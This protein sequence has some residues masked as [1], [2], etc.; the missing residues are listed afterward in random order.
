MATRPSNLPRRLNVAVES[1]PHTCPIWQVS[2]HCDSVTCLARDETYAASGSREGSVHVAL[3]PS[4]EPHLEISGCGQ[5]NCLALHRGKL[6]I[7]ADDGHHASLC[8]WDVARS[9][10]VQELGGVR[11][12]SSPTSFAYFGYSGAFWVRDATLFTLKWIGDEGR[13]AEGAAEGLPVLPGQAPNTPVPQFMLGQPLPDF[14][15]FAGITAAVH[16]GI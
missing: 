7:C 10:L 6:V 13:A 9:E 3:L 4:G 16:A 8:I 1:R 15:G 14:P 11:K 2:S 5:I 12:W